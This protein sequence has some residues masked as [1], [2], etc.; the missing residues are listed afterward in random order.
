MAYVY[1]ALKRKTMR[2]WSINHSSIARTRRGAMENLIA[3][4]STE[5]WKAETLRR[6][7]CGHIK[8]IKV[9]ILPLDEYLE[10]KE[11]ADGKS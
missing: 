10:L 8:A 5:A 9:V 6:V 4:F 7:A 1:Y 3:P 11:R 2:S